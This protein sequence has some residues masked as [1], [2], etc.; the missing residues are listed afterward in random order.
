MIKLISC[1]FTQKKLNYDQHSALVLSTATNY[2]SQFV[3]LSTRITRKVHNTELGGS[4]FVIDSLSEV[5]KY[6]GYEMDASATTC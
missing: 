3:S 1:L 6:V 4:D 2:D 5:T